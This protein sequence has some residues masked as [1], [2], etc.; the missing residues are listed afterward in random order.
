MQQFVEQLTA[1]LESDLI[2]L[3]QLEL[4]LGQEKS[5]LQQRD[6]IALDKITVQKQQIIQS[7]EKRAKQ[8]AALLANSSLKIRPGQVREKLTSLNNPNLLAVWDRAAVKLE[9]CKQ[10]NQV[11]GAIIS[12][13]LMRTN[14]LMNIL[15]GQTSLPATT[16]GQSG[17]TRNY[18]GSTTIA[19]A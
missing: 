2:E 11:N 16:Y 17:K 10:R 15:R 14:R 12:H 1:L 9:T 6:R 13:S 5:S 8:K 7:V 18:G 4:V 19:R 3:D